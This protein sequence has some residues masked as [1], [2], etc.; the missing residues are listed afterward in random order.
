MIMDIQVRSHPKLHKA[1]SWIGACAP[2]QYVVC[3]GITHNEELLFLVVAVFINVPHLF[4][5]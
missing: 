2:A 4:G 1:F 5:W 3:F